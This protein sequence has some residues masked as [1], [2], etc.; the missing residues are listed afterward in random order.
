MDIQYKG[1]LKNLK[2]ENGL[3]KSIV[4]KVKNDF[5]DL[6]SVKNNIELINQIANN[7]EDVVKFSGIIKKKV[8]KLQL[9]YKIYDGIFGV[10]TEEIKLELQKTIE[11]LDSEGKIKARSY[12]QYI[13]DVVKLFLHIT[14]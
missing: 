1:S 13:I 11:Y 8:N 4:E 2:T 6:N 5:V 3:I 14:T 9:F 12:C 7:I 10:Q